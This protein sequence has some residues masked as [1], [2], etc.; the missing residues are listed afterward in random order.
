MPP[1]PTEYF[2]MHPG[3]PGNSHNKVLQL[4]AQRALREIETVGSR[5]EGYAW[6]N[7]YVGVKAAQFQILYEGDSWVQFTIKAVN[8]YT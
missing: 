6:V 5:A 1:V 4:G 3:D 2:R 8:H 7:Y